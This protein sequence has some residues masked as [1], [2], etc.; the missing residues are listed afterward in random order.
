MSCYCSQHQP[1]DVLHSTLLSGK[2][3]LI[4]ETTL[5]SLLLRLSPCTIPPL[6]L[7]FSTEL[8]FLKESENSALLRLLLK[9]CS[10]ASQ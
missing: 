2:A 10:S 7:V 8:N 6:D 4:L 5:D 9:V 3:V 1:D